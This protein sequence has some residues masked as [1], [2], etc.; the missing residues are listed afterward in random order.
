M[1]QLANVMNTGALPRHKVISTFLV[2][3]KQK[4]FH[5]SSVRVHRLFCSLFTSFMTTAKLVLSHN[6]K[7]KSLGIVLKKVSQ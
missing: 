5:E 4:V 1:K 6:V 2:R 7:Y 3:T